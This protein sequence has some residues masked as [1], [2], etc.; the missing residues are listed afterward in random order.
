MQQKQILED[1]INHILASMDGEDTQP[2]KPEE[3]ETYHVYPTNGG[4]LIVRE[5]EEPED[6][7]TIETTLAKKKPDFPA[8]LLCIFYGFLIL[9][10]LAFS[11]SLAFF[12]PLVTV[13]IVAKSETLTLSGT[14]QLGRLLSPLT[15]SQSQTV[16][17]TGK[18]HQDATSATGFLTLYN[19]EFQSVTIAAGT[20]LTGA[21]GIQV[22]TD[23][24]V[25]IPAANP[26]R[27]GQGSISAHAVSPGIQGN[28]PAYAINQ[29]CCAVSVLAKNTTP[30]HGGQDERNFQTVAKSDIAATAATL[31]TT[32]SQSVP[33]AFQ[34][35]LKPN[36]QLYILPCSPTVTADHQAGQEATLVKVT[37]SQSCSAVAYN[38]QELEKKQQ[39]FSLSR[40]QQN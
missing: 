39:R 21:N 2:L 20:M 37:V 23:Q 11:L 19:G 38:S 30:F 32:L 26:P 22:I 9:S 34:G 14:L 17:T 5:D 24:D 6:N 35:Q 7:R 8:Y 31:K 36:E 4:I 15:I 1:Q 3:I 18:G 28:I 40:Q 33:G 25:T 29:A 10:C 16:P 27:F 12:P 13:T